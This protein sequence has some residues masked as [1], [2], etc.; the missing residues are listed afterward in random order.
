MIGVLQIKKAFFL[1]E[2]VDRAA[3]AIAHAG[4]GAERVRPRPQ[5][6]PLAQLFERMPLLLQ[7][8]LLRIGPAMHDDLAGMH[9]GGLLLAAGGLHFAAHGDAATGRELLHFGL[10]IRQIGVGDDLDVRQARTVVQLQES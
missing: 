8:I 1:K 10:V 6:G 9:F 2:I 3:D 4:H 5:M 7:R